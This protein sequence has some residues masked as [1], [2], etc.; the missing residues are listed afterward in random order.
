MKGK[1]REGGKREKE[2]KEEKNKQSH[3]SEACFF[4]TLVIG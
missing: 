1:P 3:S 4:L 2:K